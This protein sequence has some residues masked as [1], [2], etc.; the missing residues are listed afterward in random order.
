MA[1]TAVTGNISTAPHAAKLAWKAWSAVLQAGCLAVCTECTGWTH[2][3]HDAARWTKVSSSAHVRTRHAGFV[4][5]VARRAVE[6]GGLSRFGLEST[7]GTRCIS[8]SCC[9]RIK[10]C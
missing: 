6:A 7:D 4:T 5:E 1:R 10:P 2:F 8:R 9:L 3:V